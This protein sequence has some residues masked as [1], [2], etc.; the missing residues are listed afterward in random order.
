MH[1]YPDGPGQSCELLPSQRLPVQSP[2]ILLS[3]ARTSASQS[4]CEKARLLRTIRRGPEH[5]ISVALWPETEARDHSP[6]R[7][8]LRLQVPVLAQRC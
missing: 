7:G 5:P 6:H 1:P 4:V 3:K 8:S 2:W